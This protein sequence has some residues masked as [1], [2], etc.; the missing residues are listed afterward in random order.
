VVDIVEALKAAI[1]DSGQSLYQ[2]ANS[3]AAAGHAVS[4]QQLSRF[5][6]GERD[7]T[8]QSAAAV[9]G[10]LKLV[11]KPKRRGIK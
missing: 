9:C 10:V 3:T 11:L 2:I 1:A 7:L 5:L 6:R 8:L 4:H